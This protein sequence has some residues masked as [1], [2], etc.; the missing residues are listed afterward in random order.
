M[1]RKDMACFLVTDFGVLTFA[2]MREGDRNLADGVMM[3][4]RNVTS[5]LTNCNLLSDALPC[6]GARR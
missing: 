3:C 5:C 2:E 4:P 6:V 1:P